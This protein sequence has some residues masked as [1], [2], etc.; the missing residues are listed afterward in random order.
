MQDNRIN[1]IMWSDWQIE[2]VLGK[3]SY[4]TVYR[5]KK[6]DFGNV[7][8]SAVKHLSIPS[9]KSEIDS[10]RAESMTDAQIDAYYKDIVDN[11]SK[12]I[13]L[14]DA[15]K[16]TTNIVSIEDFKI[17]KR[18]NEIGWDILIR[19]ELLKDLNSYFK[20]RS[21]PITDILKVGID[22]CSALECCYREGIIHR[23][24]KPENI[25]VNKYDDFKL[26]DFGIARQ[27]QENLNMSMRGTPYYAAPEMF[28]GGR[29]DL[30][31]DIYSLGLVL[32]RLL[33]GNRLPFFPTT[34]TVSFAQRNDAIKRRLSGEALPAPAYSTP[35]LSK[36]LAKAC[37]KNPH[38]RYQ[39]PTEFKN[40]LMGVYNDLSR[41]KEVPQYSFVIDP[42]G[43]TPTP[44]TGDLSKQLDID[45]SDDAKKE[46]NK[47]IIIIAVSVVIVLTL[48]IIIALALSSNDSEDANA[49]QYVSVEDNVTV[50]EDTSTAPFEPTE[51]QPVETTQPVEST[52]EESTT[53][54]T[55]KK[56]EKTTTKKSTTKKSTTAN[57]TTTKKSTTKKKTTTKKKSTTKKKT[58]KKK[59]TKKKTTTKKQTTAQTTAA[60]TAPPV[61]VGSVGG[62]SVS[63]SGKNIRATW[64][65]ASN[66]SSYSVSVSG[67]GVSVTRTTSS[68]SIQIP[69]SGDGTYFVTVT[70]IGSD[71]S[72]GGSSSGSCDY[73]G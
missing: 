8:Y 15:L 22:L 52:T 38:Q 43:P 10:L 16:G 17:I 41:A 59:T 27:Y 69:A 13:M 36:I 18:E 51:A 55:T 60:P 61:N 20:D 53:E 63:K 25:F 29:Y 21:G 67:P 56:T 40:A 9:D 26:G 44:S 32:Y 2:S 6:S 14:M 5:V 31:V 24:I 50:I 34:G 71:G 30:T 28:E 1:E 35:K 70:P 49:D 54:S 57:K 73:S 47:K 11:I 58:T 66:A 39:T 48:V 12:E 3:G 65:R 46:L 7:I 23:D 42:D 72:Y 45:S 68:T 33:N 4:G 19:M 37:A 62:V 64:Q